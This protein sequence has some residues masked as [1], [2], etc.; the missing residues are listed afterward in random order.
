MSKYSVTDSFIS[1]LLEYMSLVGEIVSMYI[2][3][4]ICVC[5]Y[6]FIFDTCALLFILIRLISTLLHN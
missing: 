4:T 3:I 5:A 1:D 6:V 2:Y